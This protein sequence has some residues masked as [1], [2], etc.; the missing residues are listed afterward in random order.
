MDYLFASSMEQ[1]GQVTVVVSYDIACQWSIHLWERMRRYKPQWDFARHV[2]KFLVPKFHLPAHRELCHLNYSFN[3]TLHVGRTDGEAVERGWSAVNPFASSTKEMGPGSRR[4][5]LDDVFGAYNWGKITRI[6]R[7]TIHFIVPLSHC[8]LAQ[9][10]LTRVKNAINEHSIHVAA[11]KEFS[12]AL[13]AASVAQWTQAVEAWENDRS[14]L[15][16]YEV[17]RKGTLNICDV[18]M[19]CSEFLVNIA[20]TQASVRLQ[21]AQEDATRLQTGEAVPIHDH[22]SP[23]VMITYG[24]EIEDLQ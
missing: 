6:G 8:F 22:I 14:S 23:S 13:P 9:S 17:T 21:L 5:L 12:A 19:V 11:F 7:Y 18:F 15:N 24:L 4:D 3:T 1:T 10:L 16:P 2:I 20:V